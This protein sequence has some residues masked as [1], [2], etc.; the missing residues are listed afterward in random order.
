MKRSDINEL[1]GM[2]VIQELLTAGGLTSEVFRERLEEVIP[3]TTP[4][5]QWIEENGVDPFNG[6]YNCERSELPMG[7]MSDYE[8]ANELFIHG[9]D[10]PSIGEL[11]AGTKKRPIVWLTAGKERIRWLSWQNHLLEQEV[12][13]LKGL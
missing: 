2:D 3:E 6:G 7:H 11:L 13:R 12:K 5:A 4:N 1:L 8:F 10:Q 9:D